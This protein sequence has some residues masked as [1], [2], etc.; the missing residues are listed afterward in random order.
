MAEH[1]D[2]NTIAVTG[3]IM[4][5][6]VYAHPVSFVELKIV[7]CPAVTYIAGRAIACW[8]VA[9]S[10]IAMRCG[11]PTEGSTASRPAC[12][13][14]SSATATGRMWRIQRRHVKEDG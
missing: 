10:P 4:R 5:P 2:L 14:R 8:S 6:V 9:S 1:E 12:L 3:L 7:N 13:N 11:L